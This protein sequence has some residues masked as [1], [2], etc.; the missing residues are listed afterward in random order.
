MFRV[1]TKQ[2]HLASFTVD[3]AACVSYSKQTLDMTVKY[4]VFAAAA[5]VMFLQATS[6]LLSSLNIHEVVLYSMGNHKCMRGRNFEPVRM[7]LYLS[8]CQ[9]E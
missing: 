5:A 7:H 1:N 3:F 6:S 8:S 2:I 9:P 4:K